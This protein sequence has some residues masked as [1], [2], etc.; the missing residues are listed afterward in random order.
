MRCRGARE[1]GA[2]VEVSLVWI[3]AMFQEHDDERGRSFLDGNHERGLAR[4]ES[5]LHRERRL[6]V[7][8]RASTKEK[9]CNLRLTAVVDAVG[10]RGATINVERVG[11]GSSVEERLD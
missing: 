4:A 8:V 3:R 1:R 5:G 2:T 6:Q 9:L 7:D 11:I 10:Q